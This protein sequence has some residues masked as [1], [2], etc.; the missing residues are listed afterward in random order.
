MKAIDMCCILLIISL[1]QYQ[2]DHNRRARDISTGKIDLSHYTF[3]E[4]DCVLSVFQ[5]HS[6]HVACYNNSVRAF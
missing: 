5:F 2:R 3:N 4:D 6:H 1:F